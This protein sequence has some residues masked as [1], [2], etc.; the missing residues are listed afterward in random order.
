M[1]GVTT[2]ANFEKSFRRLGELTNSANAS[3]RE[4]TSLLEEI[5]FTIEQCGSAGHK[6]ARHPAILLSDFPDYNCGHNPGESVKRPY[7]KKLHK[8]VKQHEDAIKE[9]L[10]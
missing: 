8:F 7:I 9:Y 1:G 3:C 6:I 5:G 2:M 10:K 4:F